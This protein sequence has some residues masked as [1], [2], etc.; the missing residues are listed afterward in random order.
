VA[1]FRAAGATNAAFVWAPNV[2][3][4]FNSAG[5]RTRT[6]AWDPGDDAVD[7]IGL[8][9]YPQSA[10]SDVL[11]NGIDGMNAIASFAASR[12]KPLMLAERAS[13][14][15]H[16]DTAA[17]TDLVLDWAQQHP[18]TVKALVYFDF[19][20][21]GK[22]FT[23]VDRPG[24]AAEFRARTANRGRY[25]LAVVSAGQG[26]VPRSVA[27]S[28]PQPTG[29]PVPALPDSVLRPGATLRAGQFLRSGDGR[30]TA[31]LQRDGNFVVY[32]GGGR[33]LWATRTRGAASG[34]ALVMQPDGNLVLY[35]SE[36]HPLWWT[37][38]AGK[39][40]GSSLVV[41]KDGNLVLYQ[42]SGQVAWAARG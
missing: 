40:S 38:T 32:A 12:A 2:L 7:W 18:S 33:P 30:V 37:A 35:S 9:A 10:P 34:N 27:A 16:P 36:G 21:Q 29:A 23:L 19:Q 8:D 1:L 3:D 31:I 15:P 5:Q 22:D 11:L 24:A 28:S 20:T 42:G 41:Q 14:S 6:S 25:V 26:V 4:Y 13:N 17:P 39:G